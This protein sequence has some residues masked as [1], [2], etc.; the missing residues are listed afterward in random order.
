MLQK[1]IVLVRIKPFTSVLCPIHIIVTGCFFGRGRSRMIPDC[2]G[3][4]P[5]ALAGGRSVT[6][7][8]KSRTSVYTHPDHHQR[9]RGGPVQAGWDGGTRGGCIRDV[10]DEGGVQRRRGDMVSL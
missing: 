5:S 7:S 3:S 4:K 9:H 6:R 8:R 10:S 1:I 2:P